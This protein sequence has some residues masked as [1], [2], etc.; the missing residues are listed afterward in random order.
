M[1]VPDAL[2]ALRGHAFLSGL[3]ERQITLLAGLVRRLE[4][5]AG[6]LLGREGQPAETFFLVLAGRVAIELPVPGR[7]AA[8]L[9]TVGPGEVVGWSWL[10]PPHRW[11]FD[12]RA[13]EP[14][15]ALALDAT[16]L[17]AACLRDHELGYQILSRLVRAIGGRLAAAR[18]QLLDLYR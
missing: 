15:V 3:D 1:T 2:T 5:D 18:V 9:Q 10:V 17:R 6:A 16:A 14:V 11:E 8:R 7:G 12:A 4:V 13:V